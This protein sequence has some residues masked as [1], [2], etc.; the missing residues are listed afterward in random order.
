MMQ[1][2]NEQSILLQRQ[3]ESS[4]GV[5]K[6]KVGY[7]RPSSFGEAITQNKQTLLDVRKAGGIK[8]LTGWVMGRLIALFTY[9]GAF[10]PITDYQ[11]QLLATRICSK[12]YYFTPAELDYFFV[13]FEDGDY[14]VLYVGKYGVNPQVVMKA[15]LKYEEELQVAKEEEASKKSLREIS[16]KRLEY[17][18]KAVSW[19]EYCKMNDI[20]GKPNPLSEILEKTKT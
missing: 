12:F 8:K 6:D 5:I 3:Q 4:L 16:K 1:S 18:Q 13:K 15:L 10:E 2:S 20:V 9:V 19:E 14:G 17:K 7:V 11:V